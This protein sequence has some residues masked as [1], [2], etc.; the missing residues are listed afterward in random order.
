M[1]CTCT[2]TDRAYS[3]TELY[4]WL[5]T[6]G[7]RPVE[8]IPEFRH[9]YNA[10]MAFCTPESRALLEGLSL[11][12]KQAVAELFWGNIIKHEV[13]VSPREDSRADP[14]NPDNIPFFTVSGEREKLHP[15]MLN[16]PTG[17]IFAHK[18]ARTDGMTAQLSVEMTP[19]TKRLI[20]LLDGRRTIG[21]IVR[22]TLNV[23]NLPG[24]V[25]AVWN[26]WRSVY[27]VLGGYDM[28]LLRHK[29]T[30]KLPAC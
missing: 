30:P 5:A 27:Q 18:L 21:E 28:I 16:T 3:V 29:D 25:Q 8:F 23:S 7:L 13:W 6:A 12:E 26:L 14:G 1:T 11:P 20:Q 2:P 9:L 22:G 10:D 4:E 24:G 15:G 19:E 17:E